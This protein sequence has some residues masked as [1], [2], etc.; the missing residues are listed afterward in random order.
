MP[1]DLQNSLVRTS[2]AGDVFHYRW[3]ARRCLRMV[4]PASPVTAIVIEGSKEPGLD[5]EYV[6]D[7][8]EYEDR[9]DGSEQVSYFQ[10]KHST[11]RAGEP[12]VPSEL[13]GVLE[14][15]GERFTALKA[16]PAG[17]RRR[18]FAFVLVTNRPVPADIR[19]AVTELAAG[20]PGDSGTREKLANYT[21]LPSADLAAFFA[22]LSFIDGEGDYRAQKRDLRGEMTECLAGFVES[23]D[24]DRIINLVADCALP[25]AESGRSDGRIRR[26]D[27][28][29][30]LGVSSPDELF[31]ARPR[32]DALGSLVVRE[33]HADLVRHVLDESAPAII[34][35]EGGVGK[36]VAARQI[37]DS[38]PPGSL[39]IVYD[40]FGSATYRNPAQPRHR[41]RDALVQIANELAARGLCQPL[42][43][44]DAE[45]AE[46]FR[47]FTTRL[48][49]AATAL[50]EITPGAKLVV[51]IDAA[52]N[53]EM[54]AQEQQ[55]PC[56]AAPLLELPLPPGCCLVLFSRT[57]RVHLL[58][59]SPRVRQLKLREFSLPETAAHLRAKF[60]AANDHDV[61]EFHRLSGGNPRVQAQ[62]LGL[63]GAKLDEVLLNLGPRVTTVD[64]QIATRL[65]KAMTSLKAAHGPGFTAQMDNI[66]YG[67]AN[68]PPLIPIPVLARAASLDPA[69]IKSLASDLG[70]ALWASDDSVQF[71]DEPT[72]TWF[73]SRYRADP[74]RIAS[75]AAGLAPLAAEF[76]YVAKALPRLWHR[77]GDYDR[78][79]QLA[80]SDDHL[81]RNNPIDERSV[82]IDRLQ[83]AFKAALAK[84]RLKDAA[85]IAL[86]AGEETAGDT[87]QLGIFAANLDLVA[88]LLEAQRVQE[89]ALRR[90]LGRD[91]PGCENIYSAALL[92]SFADFQG[93][94]RGYL[95][96]AHRWIDAFLAERD[97]K[98]SLP[99]HR[100]GPQL[101]DEHLTE[102]MWAHF[103]LEGA[104]GFVEALGAW[105]PPEL[106][107]RVGREVIERLVDAGRFSDIEAI[108][109]HGAKL[110]FLMIG[111]TDELNRVGRLPP[112]GTLEP[113]LRFLSGAKG[114]L[115]RGGPY[116][117]ERE[118]HAGILSVLEAC[119]AERLS[120]VRISR[121][122]ARQI[123]RLANH[124]VTGEH[125]E[126]NRAQF[127]RGAALR[128]VLRGQ[129]EPA[130]KSLLP[131]PKPPPPDFRGP[132]RSDTDGEDRLAT[133]LPWHFLRTAHLVGVPN[134]PQN[135]DTLSE[136]SA[137]AQLH[138]YRQ[139]DP[140][141]VE[142]ADAYFSALVWKRDV[143]AAQLTTFFD[144]KAR[145]RD[146]TYW[147]GRR[148]PI[149]RTAFRV[150][151]L[152][153]L[154]G[155]VE[156][157]CLADLRAHWDGGPEEHAG[158][159]VG[160]AR[161]VLPAKRVEAAAYFAAA[162]DVVSKFGDEVLER[163]EALSALADHRASA[164][165]TSQETAYRFLRCAEEVGNYENQADRFDRPSALRLAARLN[166]PAGIAGLSRWRDREIGWFNEE[167]VA[168]ATDLVDRHTTEPRAGWGLTGFQA[169]RES[170]KFAVA[171]L[172]AS[173]AP[174]ERARLFARSREDLALERGLQY[175][176]RELEQLA[177]TLG[178]A[179][180][181]APEPP[182]PAGRFPAPQRSKDE[183]ALAKQ[184][185]AAWVSV[186]D[187][188]VST[189]DG[190]ARV[191]VACTADGTPQ[192][193][194][195]EVAA[196]VPSGREA[197]FLDTVLAAPD[198]N[199]ISF[200]DIVAATRDRWTGLASVNRHWP[201]FL[202]GIGRR[203][204]VSLCNAYRRQALRDF[205]A[206]SD[207]EMAVIRSGIGEG[208]AVRDEPIGAG[209]FFGFVTV[210]ANQVTPA[211]AEQL[212]DFGLGRF[213]L[214][215]KP[216]AGDGPWLPKLAAPATVPE[217]WTGF[218]WSALGSP[219][220]G[221]RWEAAH[222]VRRW[223]ELDCA[224]EIDLLIE[225]LGRGHAGAFGA[226]SFPFYAW[227]AKLC[228]LFAFRRVAVE[229][230]D[231][232]RKHAQVFAATALTGLPHALIQSYA[233]A[234]ALAIER[235][236]PRTFTAAT[237]RRLER[238]GRSPRPPRRVKDSTTKTWSTPWHLRGEVDTTLKLNFGMDFDEHWLHPLA[239]V[240]GA[241]DD[242]V[243]ELA[244]EVA[245]KDFQA[246][247][248]EEYRPDA[249]QAQ[250]SH[251]DRGVSYHK[252]EYPRTDDHQFYLAY[253]SMH[254]VAGKLLA[255]M[256]VIKSKGARR[257]DDEWRVWLR[258]HDLTRRDG[259]WLADRRD[260]LPAIRR[261][262]LKDG[263]S[264]DDWLWQLTPADFIDGLRGQTGR[265]DWIC[266]NGSWTDHDSR[267][268]ERIRVDCALVDPS[269]ADSFAQSLRWARDPGSFRLPGYRERNSDFGGPP[270]DPK[271]WIQDS[272]GGD[273]RLDRFDPFA[274]DISYPPTVIGHSYA[275]LLGLVPDVEAREWRRGPRGEVAARL[276]IWSEPRHHDRNRREGPIRAGDRL[277]VPLSLLQELCRRTKR[278]LIFCV[279]IDRRIDRGYGER[280]PDYDVPAS[281]QIFILDAHGRLRDAKQSHQL[282]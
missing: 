102:L 40:S 44:G 14:G 223:A 258:R 118:F 36:T 226:V 235:H 174:E 52:D 7:V 105:R 74:A 13:A 26:E 20:Q 87:R 35:A 120:P 271:G 197:A 281:H 230:T 100:R 201:E 29:L 47:A 180:A 28:L 153:P 221:T 212:L 12:F 278:D 238:V 276:E 112:A 141:P 67:L 10:L 266:V 128:A 242:Q 18:T 267:R 274:R 91:W 56:F 107:F 192:G 282:G 231:H 45:P 88:A 126:A 171:C 183:A 275:K 225:W 72:E 75:Y 119:A 222:C 94:G 95:R 206:V 55:Q 149:A 2:R 93:E 263:T 232:L 253:H 279:N 115:R 22:Q 156:Q 175:P 21:K 198:L 134:L 160:L 43:P 190:L 248:S 219:Y 60:P 245:T 65:D 250:W 82:R 90:T 37:A 136:R 125:N 252:S 264:G 4:H 32:F 213:E 229:C 79:I 50:A 68:L 33:Q 207:P 154:C 218:V 24:A 85:Q 194:W 146:F 96:S 25:Q 140:L 116:D 123:P 53:A 209:A 265:P 38:L 254:V 64:D 211:E 8:A 165:E 147:L 101:K 103:N 243:V 204:A 273:S 151:H 268:V 145:N 246:V 143:T 131:R 81:P 189:P 159:Y 234:I 61:R 163:W 78:L 256:P 166:A 137:Q 187:A 173:T 240:F 73:L 272:W 3:A 210:I 161:A 138:R 132:A 111:L 237:K 5:G 257:D 122:L 157:S 188:D 130:L 124:T 195:R 179:P 162:V 121:V 31:P 152:A 236:H 58:R 208:L 69:A 133:L 51:L 214:Q 27:V 57:E 1:S 185:T 249:R 220:S 98:K 148:L 239:S 277:T 155:P 182:E 127:L 270:F 34:H 106:G 193:F 89:L 261:A 92:S 244:R 83:F 217:S 280:Y 135:L 70:R 167:M 262:W 215:M 251:T 139:H 170:E 169:L 260:P 59:P 19:Q 176:S 199:Y 164:G 228:L 184:H 181:P 224:R 203:C 269:S 196:R 129:G 255:A 191:R 54:V 200:G 247:H 109:T 97:R 77:A 104:K 49:Q 172:R 39:G 86:R 168:V 227:H 177:A 11:V 205:N 117:S 16:Q 99:P 15:F 113:T 6:I 110:P 23:E 9:P 144:T 42:L 202:R 62:E 84:N 41:P 80:L 108:A 233:A 216:D 17:P 71:R 178:L 150:P 63:P 259:R 142:E 46:F 114:R 76:T 66:C 30:R 186:A 158:C 241:E 48:Q